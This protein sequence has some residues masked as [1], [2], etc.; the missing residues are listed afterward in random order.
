MHNAPIIITI[1]HQLIHTQGIFSE[2]D[3]PLD[4]IENMSTNIVLY[5]VFR[6]MF[7][8]CGNCYLRSSLAFKLFI[9]YVI[10]KKLR[11]Q[12]FLSIACYKETKYII[13]VYL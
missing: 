11:F 6:V 4:F 13:I 2:I 9:P 5:V 8:Y 3:E 12:Y 7:V 10:L 1:I